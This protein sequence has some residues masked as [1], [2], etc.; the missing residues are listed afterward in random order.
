MTWAFAAL[1]PLL[2][3][4]LA[5]I[6]DPLWQRIFGGLCTVSLGCFALSMSADAVRLGSLKLQHSIID[7]ATRPRLF[8]VITTG[9]A[10]CGLFVIGIGIWALFLK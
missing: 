3:L 6:S 1:F 2:G 5:V 7:R 4:P 10:L 8:A 9:I